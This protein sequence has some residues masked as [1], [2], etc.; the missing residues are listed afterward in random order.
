MQTTR[1]AALVT[2]TTKSTTLRWQGRQS[3]GSAWPSVTAGFLT[4]RCV[5]V[6]VC[7]RACVRV[8]VCVC[9]YA[10]VC[11]CVCV[12]VF[13][14]EPLC[15]ACARCWLPLH[16]LVHQ[17]HIYLRVC[18]CVRVCVSLCEIHYA[19]LVHAVGCPCTCL[20][21]NSISTCVCVRA[22]V[23]VCVFVR[24]PLCSACARCWLP[25]LVLAHTQKTA[26]LSATPIDSRRFMRPKMHLTCS[27]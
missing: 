2:V 7:V 6:C 23:C 10:C 27:S 20:C 12:R 9:V 22:C 1:T 17:Q 8:C 5:C 4:N 13:V 26:Y 25:L 19:V 16:V 3:A 14:R 21:T 18:A 11:V 15:S 24:E